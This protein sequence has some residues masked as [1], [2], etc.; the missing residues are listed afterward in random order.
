MSTL[1][2]DRSIIITGGST[3]IGRATALRCAEE[4]ALITIAD[5]NDDAGNEVIKMITA[6][7]IQAQYCNTNVTKAAD[8][9]NMIAQAI[10]RFGKLDGAFN[11]AGIEGN[12]TSITKMTEEE[13]DTQL[14]RGQNELAELLKQQNQL[15]VTLN[16][17]NSELDAKITAAKQELA[18]RDRE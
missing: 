7:G 11:N 18:N 10:R 16:D 9:K 6:K 17:I 15:A 1:L 8:V 4:G 12:F 14:N 2:L 5:V 3:G 13:Y